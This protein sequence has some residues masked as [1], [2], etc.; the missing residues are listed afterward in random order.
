MEYFATLTE[1]ANHHWRVSFSDCACA[2][3]GDSEMHALARASE[4]LDQWLSAALMTGELPPR[5]LTRRGEPVRVRP[6]LAI[7]IELRWLRDAR[8][9]TRAELATRAAVTE[10]EISD[11]EDPARDGSLIAL[12][13]VAGALGA[14][15]GFATA[16]APRNKGLST[17]TRR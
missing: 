10:G 14:E 17:R 16:A 13:A 4:T 8:G 11:L 12:E 15:L 1:D 5:P 9:L 7:A 2:A 3:S 6:R